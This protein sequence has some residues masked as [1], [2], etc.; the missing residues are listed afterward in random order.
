M[1]CQ[2]WVKTANQGT[3]NGSEA[4]ATIG[5]QSTGCSQWRQ[6]GTMVLSQSKTLS[7]KEDEI[8]QS[9]RIEIRTQITEV[10]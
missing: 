1:L 6:S 7:V 8:E 4:R 9:K 10:L 3:N 2:K 5:M